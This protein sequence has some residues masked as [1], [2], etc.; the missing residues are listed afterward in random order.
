MR[1]SIIIA[2]SLVLALVGIAGADSDGRNSIPALRADAY[3]KVKVDGGEYLQNFTG[4]NGVP[5]ERGTQAPGDSAGSSSGASS[6]GS[7]SS[8]ASSGGSTSGK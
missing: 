7:S 6:G 8:G 3:D 1:K 5:S 4:G 2:A